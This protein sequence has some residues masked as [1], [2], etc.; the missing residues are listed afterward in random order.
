MSIHETSDTRDRVLAAAGPVF[1]EKG[2]RDATVREICTRA[3]VNVAAVNYYF[4]DKERLYVE[5]LKQAHR[6]RAERVPLPTWKPDTPA[7]RRLRDFIKTLLVRMLEESSASWQAQIML[8]E[9]SQP[10]GACEE[11]VREF[12]RPH[13]EL[14]QSILDDLLPVDVPPAR[15][16]LI[17]FSIVGQCLHYRVAGNVVRLLVEPEEFNRLDPDRLADHITEFSLAALEG[18]SAGGCR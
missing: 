7:G 12:I 13:F 6:M 10:S 4:G 17:A 16:H 8:R 3:G 1:A 11:L 15:R 18:F 2:Y 5:S 9:I 14:L